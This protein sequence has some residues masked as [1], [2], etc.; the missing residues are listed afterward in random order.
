MKINQFT[1]GQE[2]P[3]YCEDAYNYAAEHENKIHSD[4]GA[5]QY[6]FQG[7]LVPGVA[8]YAYL[9]DPIVKAF[10]K[11]WLQHGCVTAKFLKPVYHGEEIVVRAVVTQLDP[12]TFRLELRD[13]AGELRAVGEAALAHTAPEMLTSRFPQR[14]L[15]SRKLAATIASLP[16]GTGLGSLAWRSGWALEEE[17]FLVKM[18][19][20]L[21]LYLQPEPI[22]HPAFYLA[23]ANE[24]LMANVELGSWIHTGSSVYHYSMPRDGEFVSLRGQVVESYEK[25]G[26][27]I[28]T[29]ELGLFT[30]DPRPIAR[31]RHT[32]IVR[33]REG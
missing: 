24:L 26:H 8:L 3:L 20:V 9:T 18:R 11:E 19:T 14:P 6:G 31:I 22:C 16:V 7:G 21:P 27:E 12:L 13:A 4:E 23:Q 5:A 25:R 2:L 28:V 1:L 10:G 33:L 17:G 30:E 29:L 32:A 15:P